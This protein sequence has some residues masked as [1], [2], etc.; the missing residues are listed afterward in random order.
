MFA[1]AS[2]FAIASAIDIVFTGGM[3]AA[4]DSNGYAVVAV[5]VGDATLTI[6]IIIHINAT[7]VATITIVTLLQQ[8]LLTFLLFLSLLLLFLSTLLSPLLLIALTF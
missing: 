3:A 8:R 7:I 2:D 6:A 1:V 5:P 4:I